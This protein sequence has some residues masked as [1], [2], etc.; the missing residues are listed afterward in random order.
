MGE[1]GF[2]CIGDAS[3]FGDCGSSGT[4]KREDEEKTEHMGIVWGRGPNSQ[5]EMKSQVVHM[6]E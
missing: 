1:F 3:V 6:G 5:I 2:E 4:Q